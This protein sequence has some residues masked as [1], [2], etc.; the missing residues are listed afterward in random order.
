[1]ISCAIR[2]RSDGEWHESEHRQRLEVCSGA[3]SNCIS[4]V[5]KDY[6]VCEVYEQGDKSVKGQD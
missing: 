3:F 5:A 6:L 2:G 4:S 1:M